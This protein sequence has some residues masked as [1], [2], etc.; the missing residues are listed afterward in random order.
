[1]AGLSENRLAEDRLVPLE[2]AARAWSDLS[3]QTVKRLSGLTMEPWSVAAA[4]Y[5]HGML[6]Q[7]RLSALCHTHKV[8]V[9]RAVDLLARQKQ[10]VVRL[11]DGADGRLRHLILT[12][13]GHAEVAVVAA[14]LADLRER[15]LAELSDA[16]VVQMHALLLRVEAGARR[17]P[18]VDDP[19]KPRFQV[20]QD[21]ASVHTGMKS[22]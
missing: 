2:A 3:A 8:A 11:P 10:W 1:M 12:E 5:R 21:N 9:S 14:A 18:L 17:V 16:D 15:C 19:C 6:P 7:S 20:I 13:T 22:P 4:L